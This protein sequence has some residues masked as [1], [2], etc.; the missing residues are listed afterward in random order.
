MRISLRTTKQEGWAIIN[1]D[2]R[3]TNIRIRKEWMRDNTFNKDE[4]KHSELL[5]F[6]EAK[7]QYDLIVSR[8]DICHNA[9]L[10]IK[11]KEETICK[12]YEEWISSK[13]VKDSSKR[14][15]LQAISN[16]PKNTPISSYTKDFVIHTISLSQ[17]TQIRTNQK[18]LDRL[19]GF[20]KYLYKTKKIN[21]ETLQS[22]LDVELHKA[23]ND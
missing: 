21:A 22:I 16:I 2:R 20:A 1:I 11:G 18:R 19:K 9:A 3:S 12:L 4:V 5:L 7:R 15:Y 8:Y 23:K 14:I 6:D 10:A 17:D 13:D